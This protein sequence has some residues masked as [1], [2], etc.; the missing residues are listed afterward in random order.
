[1]DTVHLPFATDAEL[2]CYTYHL[3]LARQEVEHATTLGARLQIIT[4]LR[5]LCVVPTLVDLPPELAAV[6]R[7]TPEY[8]RVKR[9]VRMEALLG[10]P[11]SYEDAT[12]VRTAPFLPPVFTKERQVLRQLRM[13]VEPAGEKM[14][15]YSPWTGVLSRLDRLLWKRRQLLPHAPTHLYV[16]GNVPSEERAAMFAD[17]CANPRHSCLLV[18]T[19]TG[20]LSINLAAANHVV[21]LNSGWNPAIEDQATARVRGLAQERAVHVTRL[22]IGGTVEAG[23]LD[24]QDRKRVMAQVMPLDAME[25]D[26]EA[27]YR[28]LLDVAVAA[29]VE[30]QLPGN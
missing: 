4:R 17:F 29:G 3:D 13:I 9:V 16:H 14:V 6:N 30:L 23:I 18:T 22:V 7:R 1:V 27:V 10:T 24:I 11:M 28:T 15:I 8:Q 12:L 26:E 5:Q 21:H 19:G 20:A 2:R 25:R